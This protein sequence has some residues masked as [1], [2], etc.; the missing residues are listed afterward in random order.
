MINIETEQDALIFRNQE[1][2][3]FYSY[4]QIQIKLK[5]IQLN[6]H[7]NIPKRTWLSLIQLLKSQFQKRGAYDQFKP[8]QYCRTSYRFE[9]IIKVVIIATR[10]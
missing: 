8:L 2:I 3:I 5:I 7:L 1:L 10:N 4:K 9:M 6:E